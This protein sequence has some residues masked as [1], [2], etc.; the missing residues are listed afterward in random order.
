MFQ[1]GEPGQ[2]SQIPMT[3]QVKQLVCTSDLGRER[4]KKNN[5]RGRL[6]MTLTR[7][8]SAGGG[9]RSQAGAS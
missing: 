3:E 4:L 7:E 2:L 5:K 8:M 6:H 9:D 1:G